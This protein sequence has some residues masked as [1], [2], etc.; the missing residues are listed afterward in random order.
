MQKE[1]KWVLQKWY[2]EK[3]G[4]IHNKPPESFFEKVAG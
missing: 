2:F 4:K 1:F 3:L